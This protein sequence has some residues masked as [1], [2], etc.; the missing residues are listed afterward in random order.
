MER[1]ASLPNARPLSPSHPAR[2]AARMTTTRERGP[3]LTTAAVLF[4]MLVISN[5]MKPLEIGDQTGFVFLGRRLSGVGN[6]L[7][8]VAAAYLAVYAYGIWTMRRY[9][10]TM[11]WVYTAYVV[12]NL[13]LFPFR[14]PTPPG[15]LYAIFGL[16]YAVV[17]IG[18]SAGTAW[19]LTKRKAELA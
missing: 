12:V 3:W 15:I 1:R 18:M 11:G 5:A 14:T 2:Y 7:G 19:M 8:I 6:L 4:G 17:A 9:A 16:V 13:V 10:V